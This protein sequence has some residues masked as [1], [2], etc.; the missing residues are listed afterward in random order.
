MFEG[1]SVALS[2]HPTTLIFGREYLT[3][4]LLD[5][6]FQVSSQSFF[7]VN[8]PAAEVLY[9]TSIDE[10]K[11]ST[12]ENKSATESESISAA[13]SPVNCILDICCGTGTIGI[14]AS[15]LLQD[16]SDSS[17][18]KAKNVIIGVD[19]CA[20]AIDNANKNATLNEIA[21]HGVASPSSN[22]TA[23]FVCSK[24]EAILGNLLRKKRTG[25]S[26]DSTIMGLRTLL[27]TGTDGEYYA[28]VDP[29]REGMFA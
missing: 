3:E 2:D 17:D 22:T 20:T 13:H 4:T 28:I 1:L 9:R 10:L 5:C 21:L 6:K 8:T 27:P 23:S 11:S 12:V 26:Y 24:A 18:S 7:Q 25:E 29:P 19:I 15:K 16:T 14:C